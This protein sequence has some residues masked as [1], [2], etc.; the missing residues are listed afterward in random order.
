MFE[1]IV[2]T[3]NGFVWG[4]V[5]LTLLLGTGIYLTIGLKGMTIS[6]IP[7]A[8]RQLFKGRKS[9]GEGEI[10]PF[11]ALMTSLSSTIGMGNIAGV[12]T[13]IGLGGPGALFWMWCAAFVGMATKY[14]EAVLAVNYRETDELGRKVGGP[15][16]YIKNGLGGNWKWLGMAFALFGSLAGFGLANTVQSNAVSQVLETNFAVPTVVSGLVM[17]VLVGTVLLGGIKR[18]AVVAG[19]LVPFMALLY[20][21]ATLLILITHATDIPAAVVLVVDSAFNGAAAT[22][23][24]AGATLMLALRMGIARGIFSNEAGLGSAP[25]AHAAAETNSPVRQGTIAMLGTFIDTL[26]ICTMTGLVLIVTGVWSG[27]PQ[28]AAMTLAAFTSALPFGDLLLS[29]CVAL[30]AF[31]TMLGWSYYGERC[32]EFLLGPRV[33]TPFRV[34]W[35]IGIFVG[36]QMSLELVWKMTDALNGLMAIPNLI[37]LIFLSPVVFKLTQEYFADEAKLAQENT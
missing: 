23:G 8:F 34:L 16:Y 30:F 18:I 9:S 12:A 31:T 15:M 4:P 10:T 37:A 6:H 28:G 1:Q 21:S 2:D 29:I 11:N 25:I 3:V 33:I 7:Y 24:F 36:T 14:A 5:M 35:V 20:I 17:A 32:A 26:V 13:A 19:K 27:E 22:G